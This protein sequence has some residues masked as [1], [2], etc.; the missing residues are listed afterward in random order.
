MTWK[1]GCSIARVVDRILIRR[2]GKARPWQGRL[3]VLMVRSDT[4]PAFYQ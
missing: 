1:P 4:L 2:A 3:A